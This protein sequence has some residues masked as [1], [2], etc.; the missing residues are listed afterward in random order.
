MTKQKNKLFDPTDLPEKQLM[1]YEVIKSNNGINMTNIVSLLGFNKTT[2]D[3][4]IRALKK[5]KIVIFKGTN[6]SGGCFNTK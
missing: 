1:V 4:A 3:N 5:K 2:V 6:K